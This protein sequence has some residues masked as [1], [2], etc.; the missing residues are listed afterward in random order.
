MADTMEADMKVQ[1]RTSIGTNRLSIT[2]IWA[3]EAEQTS[4]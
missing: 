3:Q 2:I 1:D 4:T